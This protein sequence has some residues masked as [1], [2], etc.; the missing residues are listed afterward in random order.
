MP[1]LA[2]EA[3]GAVVLVVAAGAGGLETAVEADAGLAGAPDALVAAAGF[4]A[5]AAFFVGCRIMCT[6]PPELL[7]ASICPLLELY[8]IFAAR[9]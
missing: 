6:W 4:V 7:L 3:G 5:G 9:V 1:A 2:P 8:V